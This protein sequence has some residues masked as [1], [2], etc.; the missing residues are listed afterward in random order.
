M[1]KF[2]VI[3]LLLINP[4]ISIKT[5]QDSYLGK[6]DV[7]IGQKGM[8]SGLVMDTL[9]ITSKEFIN[10]NSKYKISLIDDNRISLE[11]NEKF[12]YISKINDSEFYYCLSK[13]K[14]VENYNEG[15]NN[16]YWYKAKR[17]AK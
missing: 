15:C 6:Y 9:D 14:P 16:S 1:N 8:F 10:R 4:C 11:V 3:I 12:I 2:L 17:K 5:K 13:S 7:Y